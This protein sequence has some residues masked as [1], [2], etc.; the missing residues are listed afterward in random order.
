MA[1]HYMSMLFVTCYDVL[2]VFSAYLFDV[3]HG[4]LMYFRNLYK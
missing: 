2:V 4:I 3:M 1:P